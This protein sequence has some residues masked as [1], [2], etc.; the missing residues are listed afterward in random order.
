MTKTQRVLEFEKY[1]REHPGLIEKMVERT[2]AGL[3][4][5]YIRR[6]IHGVAEELESGPKR[7][8]G[9]QFNPRHAYFYVMVIISL[10]PALAPKITYDEVAESMFRLEDALMASQGQLPN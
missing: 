3:E 5:G 7:L 4:A 6:T 1:V 2:T 10:V 8:K 9:F